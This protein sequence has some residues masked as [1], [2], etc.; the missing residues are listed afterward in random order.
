[1]RTGSKI[2]VLVFVV[3]AIVPAT[4]AYVNSSPNDGTVSIYVHDKPTA[5]ASAV[6]I[7]FSSVSLHSNKTGWNNYTVPTTTINIQ[8]LSTTNESLLKSITLLA[9]HYTM[10]RLY[11]Q[12][13]SVIIGGVNYAFKL[14]APF[15]FINKPFTVQQFSTTTISIDFNLDECLNL[16]AHMFTPHIGYTF[17]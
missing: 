17:S 8:G 11:I 5:S 3:L 4:L 7:T 2:A 10:I 6:Y 9:D 12:N 15:A 14:S 1:M 13:V 16:H